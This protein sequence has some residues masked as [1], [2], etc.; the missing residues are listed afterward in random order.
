MSDD[1]LAEEQEQEDHKLLAVLQSSSHRRVPITAREQTQIIAR[2][3]ERL[4]QATSASSLPNVV[5]LTEKSQFVPNTPMAHARKRTQFVSNLLA[6]LVVIG[7]ILGSWALFR[8]YPFSNGTPV[9]TSVSGKG[10]TAQAQ[11]GGLEASMRVLIGGPYFLSELLP[12]DVSLTNHTQKPVVL[13][14]TNSTATLCFSSALLVQVTEGDHPSY[15]F[16]KLDIACTAIGFATGVKPGQ[17]ITIH[18]YAPLTKSR[19]VTLS[20]QGTFIGSDHTASPLDGHWPTVHIQVNPQVPQDRAL[21]LQNQERQVMIN[22]PAGAKAHLL[23]LQTITCDS[24]NDS[25]AVQWTALSTTV[26]HEPTC[27]TKHPHWEYIVSAP[28]Y[29]IVSGS[30]TA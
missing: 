22:I 6:A 14:G 13:E 26:L 20:M 28:G 7:I 27:P 15:T 1:L 5:A 9:S 16:P 18:Q 19:E 4:A 29:S 10:P 21:S 17:T 12:I 25:R 8:A 30:Q 11:A 23:Y 24:Y 2:V 3:R